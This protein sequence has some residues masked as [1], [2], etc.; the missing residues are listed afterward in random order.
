M[1]RRV[2]AVVQRREIRRAAREV[3]ARRG[4]RVVPVELPSGV[5]H[6]KCVC[7]PLGGGRVLLAEGS[8]PASVFGGA[9]VVTIPE[10][11]TYAANVVALGEHALVAAG[12]PRTR[13]VLVD[14]GF[15]VHALET[16]EAAKADGSLT[17]QSI[18]FA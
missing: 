9:S 7:S 13:Y 6:L 15:S 17:C 2:D 16:T 1:P 8:V 11:E 14:L 18:L 3:F 5:L 4:L 10:A 12:H